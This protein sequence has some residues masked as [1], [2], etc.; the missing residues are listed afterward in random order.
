MLLVES[1]AEEMGTAEAVENIEVQALGNGAIGW[2]RSLGKHRPV[3]S[4]CGSERRRREEGGKGG[5]R[6]K[7]RSGSDARIRV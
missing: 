6:R 1:S 4:L 2:A 7:R 5:K 3:Q